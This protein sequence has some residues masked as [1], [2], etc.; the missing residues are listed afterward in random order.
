MASHSIAAVMPG[1]GGLI[2]LAGGVEADHGVE[3][4]DAAGLVLR[5]LDE[6]QPHQGAQV[7]LGDAEQ[8]GQAAGHIGGEPAPQRP[9]HRR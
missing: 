8:A 9:P 5:H 6:P 4:D 2:V 7:F 1:G 3:V